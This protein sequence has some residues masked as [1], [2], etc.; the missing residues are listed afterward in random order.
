MPVE[1]EAVANVR[2]LRFL[3]ACVLALL[4]AACSSGAGKPATTAPPTS[5]GAVESPT[6]TSHTAGSAAAALSGTWKGDWEN[7]SPDSSRGTFTIQWQQLG[8]GL[9]GTI[10]V[11]GTP[12]L[13]GGSISG[14]VSGDH[15]DFG[16][17]TGQAQVVYTG[18]VNGTKMS[19]TY[20]TSCGNAQGN[21]TA[22]KS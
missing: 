14:S 11:N 4:C 8:T 16:V 6:T 13:T 19:G 17:V 2:R 7:T 22:T 21:W 20:S 9:T 12:C 10:T 1:S 3:T 18:S 15:I 5:V